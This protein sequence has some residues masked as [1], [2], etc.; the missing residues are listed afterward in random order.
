MIDEVRVRVDRRKRIHRACMEMAQ[1]FGIGYILDQRGPAGQL[2]RSAPDEGIPTIDPELG[3][4]LGWDRE[5][6]QKGITGVENVLKYYG[7]IP[8]EPFIPKKQVVVDGFL[9]VLANRGGFIEFHAQ[10]Y[11][12]LQKDD[13]VADI[14]D[15]FGTV[16]ET[17]RAPEESIFWSENLLPM[18]SSGEMV[19]TLGK[20]IRYV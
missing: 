20:N 9:T 18:V 15:P 14:T 11:D 16:L 19:A 13:P 2:A 3:G 1:V 8:G 7:V 6:I 10:H 12:H 4:C 5:S 17:L